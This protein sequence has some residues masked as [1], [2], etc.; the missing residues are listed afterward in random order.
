MKR[1]A[2]HIGSVR[3][4]RRRGVMRAAVWGA[5]AVA[6]IGALPVA[7]AAAASAAPDLDDPVAG[8]AH[9]A[10]QHPGV[11][12]DHRV[13]PAGPA[14]ADRPD[15]G[16]P[17]AAQRPGVQVRVGLPP[18]L[19]QVLGLH[20]GVSVDIDRNHRREPE[21]DNRRDTDR[22]HDRRT[23]GPQQG[24]GQVGENGGDVARSDGHTSTPAQS[25]AQPPTATTPANPAPVSEPVAGPAAPAMPADQSSIPV[26]PE[27]T[28]TLTGSQPV[29]PIG[30]TVVEVPIELTPGEPFTPPSGG[31]LIAGPN[32]T[33]QI[34]PVNPEPV[35]IPAPGSAGAAVQPPPPNLAG[36]LFD[37]G[38]LNRTPVFLPDNFAD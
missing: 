23:D 7:F 31:Q 25:Q 21:R 18:A 38:T 1:P 11:G 12:S 35:Y 13:A 16:A 15:S 3:S 6:S 2:R 10:P 5:A 33:V 30:A 34:G 24:R 37:V 22:Q 9:G 8:A 26:S 29:P 32:Q 14:P 20:G 17:G 28:P 19:E 4:S 27:I 36:Q